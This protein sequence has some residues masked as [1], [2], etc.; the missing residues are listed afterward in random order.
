MPYG[1]Y[2]KGSTNGAVTTYNVEKET[3]AANGNGTTDNKWKKNYVPYEEEDQ[4]EKEEEEENN[5]KE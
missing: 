2:P 1:E 4:M 3:N 5:G